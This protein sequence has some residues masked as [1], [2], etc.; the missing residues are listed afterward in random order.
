[1]PKAKTHKGAAK[2]GYVPKKKKSGKKKKPYISKSIRE[3]QALR[4]SND[5]KQTIR[6]E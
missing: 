6:E 1:M 2:R 3:A 4:Q 5:S